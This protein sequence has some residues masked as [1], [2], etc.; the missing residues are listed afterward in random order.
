FESLG[1]KPPELKDPVTMNER[2]DHLDFTTSD[3]VGWTLDTKK[4]SVPE[5]DH[6]M[7][8]TK[9]SFD[10]DLFRDQL[11]LWGWKGKT[12]EFRMNLPTWGYYEAETP[13]VE[14][15]G[16]GR[17]RFRQK[18]FGAQGY[19]EVEYKWNGKSFEEVAGKP[20]NQD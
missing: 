7:V 8:D 9:T 17:I 4:L 1:T 14:V 13:P 18:G 15:I 12:W 20:G 2:C 11:G 3:S 10:S 16:K 5:F 6:L 19:Q